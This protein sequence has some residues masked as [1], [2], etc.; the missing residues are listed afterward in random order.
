[1]STQKFRINYSSINATLIPSLVTI[2]N[3]ALPNDN[4][5]CIIEDI[6]DNA[7]SHLVSFS[8]SDNFQEWI[9]E[10]AEVLRTWLF[11]TADIDTIIELDV[12]YS[13]HLINQEYQD[14]RKISINLMQEGDTSGDYLYITIKDVT[15]AH[16]DMVTELS[17]LSKET[18]VI[19]HADL[20]LWIVGID[21]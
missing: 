21:V 14:V 12:D 9:T 17:K 10:H 13:I 18:L 1:M 11:G 15:E 16:N 4:L 8:Q 20:L 5:F 7:D 6:F 2:C 19:N 3:S